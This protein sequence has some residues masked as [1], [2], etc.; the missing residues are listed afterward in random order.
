MLGALVVPLA[1]LPGAC[2]DVMFDQAMFA[3]ARQLDRDA[4]P[5]P[6][7]SEIFIK[8]E[9]GVDIH[10][11]FHAYTGDADAR[12]AL[13]HFHGNGEH[14]Y[15]TAMHAGALAQHA[16]VLAV[17][18]RGYGKSGGRPTEAGVY[19]DAEAAIRH[20]TD[21]KN[22]NENDIFIYGRSLGAAVAVELAKSRTLRGL[23][24]EAPF[25]SGRA[26]A[27]E[28]GL[29]WVPGLGEPFDS[30]AKAPD[31]R[32]R[33]LVIHGEDDRIVPIHQG[34]DLFRKFAASDKCFIAVPDAGHNDVAEVGGETY[35]RWLANFLQGGRPQ[36]C[37]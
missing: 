33:V 3:P 17:S 24:L 31:I 20:L 21:E 18:Y 15:H 4:E 32:S 29:G 12:P 10:A 11:L 28:V 35:W 6:G 1:I 34:R 26:M 8:T 13:L 9:D 5:P 16:D 14:V 37:D 22:F 7:V 25:S 19:L 30:L 27:D 23:V 2:G 36:P